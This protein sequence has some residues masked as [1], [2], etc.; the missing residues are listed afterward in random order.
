MPKVPAPATPGCGLHLGRRG[1]CRRATLG[2]A[3]MAAWIPEDG[4]ALPPHPSSPSPPGGSHTHLVGAGRSRSVLR[5]S[6]AAL[7]AE[8][9]ARL[10]AGRGR[11]A[12]LCG[13]SSPRAPA[14]PVYARRHGNAPAWAWPVGGRGRGRTGSIH[15]A[16]TQPATCSRSLLHTPVFP[17]H[18]WGHRGRGV[19]QGFRA[20]KEQSGFHR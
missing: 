12:A 19:I 15:R 13:V 4:D 1:W 2:S 11:L 18:R 5:S 3:G 10:N 17:F 14:R 6:H 16:G 20:R 8:A 7:A 9:P